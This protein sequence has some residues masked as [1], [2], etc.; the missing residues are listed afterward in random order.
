M[1][2]VAHNNINDHQFEIKNSFFFILIEWFAVLQFMLID[3]SVCL[4]NFGNT[5]QKPI[6]SMFIN[7]NK[8]IASI[9]T[10]RNLHLQTK[11]NTK[12]S[13]SL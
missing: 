5:K 7:N 2:F 1:Y 10:E 4:K 6:L 13:Y 8:K 12:I 11:N 3:N 9:E